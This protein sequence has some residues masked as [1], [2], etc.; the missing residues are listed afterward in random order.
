[1]NKLA[2][3]Y[4]KL[5][6]LM[7]SQQMT[8]TMLMRKANIS[9]NIISRLRHNEYVSLETIENICRVFQCRVDAVLD[10]KFSSEMNIAPS[11]SF[12]RTANIQNRRYLGNKFKLLKFLRNVVDK[13]CTAVETVAD[14]FSGTGAV[15]S[16]FMDKTIITNDLL[17]SNYLCNLAW[18]G[19]EQV[20][21]PLLEN[22]IAKYN[23]ITDLPAN[24]MT[25]NFADTYFSTVDCTKIGFVRE[26]VEEKYKLG[27]INER[28]RAALIAALIYAM[29]KIAN[30]CGHYDA[31]RHG[32]N[33][34][35]RLTLPLLNIPA[36]NNEQNQCFNED[37]NE[38]VRQIKA[39]LI[40]IDPPYNSR[41][42]SDTYHLLENVARWKKSPVYGVAR[43]MDRSNLK[44][45]YCTLKATAA[46]EELI[47][48]CDAKYIL[49]SYNNMANKG[50][51]RS[52][53]R[54]SDEDIFRILNAKGDVE[55]F[56]AKY[57]PFT[58]GKSDI[59]GNE[60]RL[61][62]CKVRQRKKI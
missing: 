14:I 1:M 36:K 37:A 29:D 24:Y 6:R 56:S 51:A 48:H 12:L 8:S 19:R 17:Y 16:A 34:E 5:F 26:D 38:L 44:S 42:Y 13:N 46:F 61:F 60:E 28:E 32:A 7:E 57:K 21:L 3:A 39:D 15:A 20:R 40:Y 35:R 30:T 11:E 2:V 43:K 54:I 10:F 33:F 23:Q 50:D 9:G 45:D 59:R 52:N 41:Q 4:D 22:L 62:L 55:V 31:W 53:A 47:Q 58:A 49:F 18:F 27:V 25:D